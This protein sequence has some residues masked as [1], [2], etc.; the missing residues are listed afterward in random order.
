MDNKSQQ[1]SSD[2]PR[3]RVS[4]SPSSRGLR[5]SR[6]YFRLST[7]VLTVMA[8]IGT[9]SLLLF[10]GAAVFGLRPMVVISASMEPSIRVGSLLL[11]VETTS[12]ALQVGD[13][14]TVRAGDTKH[15]VT[16]RIVDIK[17][18]EQDQ[19]SFTT[20][21]DANVAD[22]PREVVVRSAPRMWLVIPQMGFAVLWMRT[23]G[24]LLCLASA[25]LLLAV[26]VV[27]VP[28]SDKGGKM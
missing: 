5:F 18:C 14:V 9:L 20:K 2:H 4:T 15:L 8:C 16:H 21:G 24:G 11:S 27:Y 28:A 6:I 25:A 26:L 12:S 17:G 1:V 3:M 19:C 22:D 7:V 13:V 10:I 23:L